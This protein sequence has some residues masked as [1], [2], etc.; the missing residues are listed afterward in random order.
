MRAFHVIHTRVFDRSAWCDS[1]VV[2]ASVG[3]KRSD[4]RETGR[5]ISDLTAEPAC[6]CHLETAI[7]CVDESRAAPPNASKSRI[8]ADGGRSHRIVVERHIA[9]LGVECGAGIGDGRRPGNGCAT[10]D[11]QRGRWLRAPSQGGMY[12]DRSPDAGRGREP[13]AP[14]PGR[15]PPPATDAAL[16]CSQVSGAAADG[17]YPPDPRGARRRRLADDQEPSTPRR[18][19]STTGGLAAM[20][21]PFSHA[22]RAER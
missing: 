13:D 15:P 9:R 7:R 18:P 16:R 17:R 3:R 11:D 21:A 6:W 14:Y 2:T 4:D 8:V 19:G 12:D 1:A 20:P 10:G 5:K 22:R